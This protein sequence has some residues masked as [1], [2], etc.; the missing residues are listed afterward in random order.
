M[1]IYRTDIFPL[2]LPPGHPFPAAKYAVLSRR[3][4]QDGIVAGRFKADLA[5]YLAGADPYHGDRYGGM[6]LTK[7]G[8]AKRD[9]YVLA[10]CRHHRLPVAVTMAGGYARD[11]IDTVDI[12][13]E[14]V[15]IF[16]NAD[17]KDG[18]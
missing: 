4:I 16:V 14:T 9:R 1:K 5:I 11:I 3:L 2:D 17:K 13:T 15:R 8:L 18:T 10:F 12:H 6:S 7:N